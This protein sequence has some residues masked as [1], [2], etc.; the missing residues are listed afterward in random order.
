[1]I[2]VAGTKG[3]GSTCAFVN[4][5]LRAHAAKTGYPRKIGL[6]TSPHL[7]R[8]EERFRIN[9]KPISEDAFVKYVFEVWSKLSSTKHNV[10]VKN[11]KPSLLNSN[12]GPSSS[13]INKPLSPKT[14]ELSP[15]A[16]ESSLLNVDTLP[17]LNG[18]LQT[19][20]YL[21]FLMLLS[22]HTFISEGVDVAIYETHSGGEFDATNIFKKPVVTGITTLGMDHVDQLGPTLK[23]IAWHKGGILK[24]GTPAFSSLQEPLAT[25]IL[26]Q[27][28]NE[29]NV[30]LN[31]V[32]ISLSL[33]PASQL[34]DTQAQ[35]VNSS[36]ALALVDAFLSDKAPSEHQSMTFQTT[37]QGVNNFFWPGRFHRIVHGKYQW[38]LDGAH[39]DTSLQKAA[40]W[41]AKSARDVQSTNILIFSQ[42]SERDGAGLL[43]ILVESLQECTCEIDH[44]IFSSYEERQDGTIRTGM[45][46]GIKLILISDGID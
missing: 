17:S 19:P 21:Q 30:T 9:S 44:V 26:Q 39:N 16:V 38:F 34:L 14:G 1:M 36:L 24:E 42:V 5:F 28:A 18:D 40:Q 7:L 31:F 3:K 43:K 37:E 20:R 23:N 15:E 41:F 6:Y 4:S 11:D 2:H 10:S 45:I 35:K 29:K 25:A 22:I 13:E 33:P 12:D 27:R 46:A 32:D 8:V